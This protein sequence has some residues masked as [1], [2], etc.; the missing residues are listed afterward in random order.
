[1]LIIQVLYL[2]SVLLD[3]TVMYLIQERKCVN[4]LTPLVTTSTQT[5]MIEVLLKFFKAPEYH[6]TYVT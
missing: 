6:F 4:I 3:K 2:Y 5:V 1:M